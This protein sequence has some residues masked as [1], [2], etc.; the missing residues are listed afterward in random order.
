[1]NDQPQIVATPAHPQGYGYR[2]WW[3]EAVAADGQRITAGG[4]TKDHAR[5]NAEKKLR[6][7][8]ER[9]EL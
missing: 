2:L 4:L 6:Q 8:Q 1:M 5:E 9:N 3:A 7:L